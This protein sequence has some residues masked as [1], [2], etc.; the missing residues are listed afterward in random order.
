[1]MAT[2]DIP[3]NT[4]TAVTDS[5]GIASGII[6][7][8]DYT[9]NNSAL[10]RS[11]GAGGYNWWVSTFDVGAWRMIFPEAMDIDEVGV[12]GDNV[13]DVTLGHICKQTLQ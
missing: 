3:Q 10:H 1:M 5:N 8:P 9:G 11:Y 7:L 2:V 4:Y 12:G 13:P 6:T